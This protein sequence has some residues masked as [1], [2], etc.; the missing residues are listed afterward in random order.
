MTNVK[1]NFEI[2]EKVSWLGIRGEIQEM[3]APYKWLVL[4]AAGDE[5]ETWESELVKVGD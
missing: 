5:V 1:S 4:T 3:L 2:G